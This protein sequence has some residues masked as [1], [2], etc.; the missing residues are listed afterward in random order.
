MKQRLAY[1]DNLKGLL[2]M[3]VVLGHCIQMI[4]ADFSNN[5]VFRYIYAF[6]MPLFMALSGYVCCRPDPEW[7]LLRRRT[8][9]LLVPF[10]SWALL[11]AALR[12]RLSDF[13]LTL[14]YPDR[15]LWFLY[16]LFVVTVLHVACFKLFRL[17]RLAPEWGVALLVGVLMGVKV[18][19]RF[20]Y[21]AFPHVAWYFF[22]YHVGFFMRKYED[23]ISERSR[24]VAGLLCL[25]LFF[26]LA[27]WWRLAAPPAFMSVACPVAVGSLYNLSTALFACL[28][29][30]WVGQKHLKQHLPIITK[31]GWITL[32]IYAIH[33]TLLRCMLALIPADI[34]PSQGAEVAVCAVL[35]LSG[36]WL[37]LEALERSRLLSFLFL[38]GS[39][40]RGCRSSFGS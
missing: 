9:Q 35:C 5:I 39:P 22:F 40:V 30:I 14:L 33:Q 28:G 36:S 16:V 18:V 7:A 37:V 1:I 15:G 12:G 4:C 38:G 26:V 34:F 2:I 6:H 3:L 19:C 13:P 17:M 25:S 10:L 32:G 29:F 20:D 31:M 11:E 23:K 21:L 24:L 27:Y 8:F